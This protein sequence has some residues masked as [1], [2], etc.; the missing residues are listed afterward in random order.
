MCTT[1]SLPLSLLSLSLHV[2]P[3]CISTCGG[4]YKPYVCTY[5]CIYVSVYIYIYY[6]YVHLYTPCANVFFEPSFPYVPR[7]FSFQNLSLGSFSGPL[8]T[9]RD[10]E[11]G[12][13]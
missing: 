13:R 8:E 10:G 12:G 2:G 5:I 7:H 3:M 4:W 11:H 9:T 1:N 6:M